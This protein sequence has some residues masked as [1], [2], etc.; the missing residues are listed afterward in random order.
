MHHALTP[1]WPS[2]SFDFLRDDLGES[3]TRFPHSLI[4]AVG[5]QAGRPQDN[6][7]TIMKLSDLSKIHVE[8]EDDILG[9]EYKPDGGE[10]DD[11]DSDDEEVDL[12]PVLENFSI[13]HHGGINR[14]RAMPQKSNIIA[15][16]SDAGQVNL[17]DVESVLAK[18][19]S[20]GTKQTVPSKEMKPFFTHS[21]HSTEGYALDW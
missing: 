4:A 10:D 8:T 11:D 5:T 17:F 9:D 16:W 14:I 3:R 1:E 7:L 13:P 19:S 12:D 6:Q 2:L 15:T 18:F 20:K 21:G